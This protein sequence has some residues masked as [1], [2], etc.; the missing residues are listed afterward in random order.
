[1]TKRFGAALIVALLLAG[2]LGHALSFS[3]F[4][5]ITV[6]NTVKRFT[7]ALITPS[8]RAQATQATCRLETAEIRFTIDGTTPTAAIG[9]PW[10]ALEEKTF[11][12]HDVLLT[13]QAIRTGA[14]SG[15]LDCTYSAP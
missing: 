5:Q 4:E 15:Q 8:G 7:A 2:L 13:F 9:M 14:V 6:D 10:E 1:M 11:N 3:A 12:G